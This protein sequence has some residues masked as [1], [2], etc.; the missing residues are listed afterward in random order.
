MFVKVILFAICISVVASNDIRL[1]FTSATSKRLYSEIKEASPALWTRT[2]DIVVNALNNEIISAVF[3]TDLRDDKDG[4]A[5][6]ESGGI[7][8][9]SVTIG[10]KSPSI[11]RG[12][13]F[14]IEV[15]AENPSERYHSKGGYTGPTYGDTQFARKY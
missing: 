4:Q 12:Y 1:G 2:D 11:L 5:F 9:K 7:G 8:G 14:N 10:L 3:V 13:R 15:F 6:I